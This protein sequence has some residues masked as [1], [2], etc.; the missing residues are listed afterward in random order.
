MFNVV[1]IPPFRVASPGLVKNTLSRNDNRH[2]YQIE[3]YLNS[4]GKLLNNDK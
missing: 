1:G 3:E 4:N 2:G